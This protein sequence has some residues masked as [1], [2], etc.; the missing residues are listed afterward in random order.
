MH[1]V[2][3][4]LAHISFLIMEPIAVTLHGGLCSLDGQIFN[5]F[6]FKCSFLQVKPTFLRTIQT[7]LRKLGVSSPGCLPGE[8]YSLWT[9]L[10][11]WSNNSQAAFPSTAFLASPVTPLFHSVPETA[12]HPLL[13]CFQLYGQAPA[14]V[15]HPTGH[16]PA[17]LWADSHLGTCWLCAWLCTT[18][19]LQGVEAVW[20]PFH[21]WGMKRVRSKGSIDF[22][23]SFEAMRVC[24]WFGHIWQFTSLNTPTSI[25]HCQP[26]Q[27]GELQHLKSGTKK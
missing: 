5:I 19:A 15:V 7:L 3:N 24:W 26:L 9:H 18:A 12:W 11:C 6:C 23:T 20:S 13:C 27:L 17:S 21:S 14:L 22:S 25:V 16:P 4:H 8:H 10:K 2:W 1:H